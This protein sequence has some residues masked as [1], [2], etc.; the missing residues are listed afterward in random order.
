[1]TN[2]VAMCTAVTNHDLAIGLEEWCNAALCTLLLDLTSGS[3]LKIGAQMIPSNFNH[4][5]N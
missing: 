3:G 2:G 1:L 4:K 5:L